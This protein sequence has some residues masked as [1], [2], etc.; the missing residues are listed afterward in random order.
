MKE[1]TYLYFIESGN[2]GPVKIGCAKDVQHR[3]CYLQIGNPNKLYL[4]AQFPIEH[5]LSELKVHHLL[6]SRWIRGEWYEAGPVKD[7]LTRQRRSGRWTYRETEE[8][9]ETIKNRHLGEPNTALVATRISKAA[10]EALTDRVLMKA[11]TVSA[12]L[13]GLILADL[14]GQT[15]D[16]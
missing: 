1:I 16:V 5:G 7:L 2:G 15:G 3:L 12:Y 9:Q 4:L 11:T 8:E 13:R 6:R 14:A 10:A